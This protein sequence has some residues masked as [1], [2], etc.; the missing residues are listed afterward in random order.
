M[1]SSL[2]R[3]PRSTPFSF[4]SPGIVASTAAAAALLASCSVSVDP[5]ADRDALASG[6]RQREAPRVR[7]TPIVRREM[8]RLLETTTVIESEAEIALF[9]RTSGI[10]VEVLAEEG[11]HVAAGEVLARLDDRDTTLAARDAE[12]ALDEA[13]NRAESAGIAVQEARAAI[14]NAKLAADQAL[15]DHDRNQRLFGGEAKPSALSEQALE[16]SGLELERRRHEVVQAELA[17]KKSEVEERDTAIAVSRAEVALERARVTREHTEIRAPFDGVIA[18][19][20]IRV[21][22]MAGSSAVYVLTDVRNLRAVFHRPQ[23]ELELFTDGLEPGNGHGRSGPLGVSAVAEALP[24]H[25]FAGTIQR[26]SPTVDANSGSFRVTASL[27]IAPEGRTEPRLL[28]GMLVRLS[29]VTDR[30][31]DALVAPK[32]AVRREADQSFVLV[33]RDGIAHRVD[34]AEGYADDDFVEIVVLGDGVLAPGDEIVSVGARELADGAPITVE[35]YEAPKVDAVESE[36]P[37][38]DAG[39]DDEADPVADPEAVE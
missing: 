11:D 39:T 4:F 31:P 19:R 24:G 8:V 35:A 20:S 5:G 7:T 21:G 9:P 26:V 10:V 14:D 28:P 16:T 38:P 25:V 13:K 33:A 2:T 34:V 27:S 22:D 1:R 32:R 37:T 29:I 36:I 15:R 3:S 30:H 6:A 18:S 23:R 17:W 12:V